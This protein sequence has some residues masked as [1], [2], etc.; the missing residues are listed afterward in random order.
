MS[1]YP[2]PERAFARRLKSLHRLGGWPARLSLLLP[3]AGGALLVLQTSTLAQ[4]LHRAVV[5]QEAIAGLVGPLAVVLALVVAR[6]GIGMLGEMLAVLASEAIKLT[7]RRRF[8]G[9]M[10]DRLPIWTAGQSSGALSTLIIEQIESLDG[11]FT[12]Y[13]PAMVQAAVLPIAFAV[14]VFPVDWTVGLIFLVTA[15][16]IPIFM[17]LA[18]WG[19]EA[20]SRQQARAL[21]RLTG[22]FADRLRGMVTL[23]LFGREEAETGAIF[24]SSEE[25]RRRSMKVMRIAFLSSAVLEFFSALGVAGVALYCGL[26]LLGLI[27]LRSTPMELEAALFCLLMAPEVYQPLRLLAASY[28]DRA[29]ARAALQEIEAGLAPTLQNPPTARTAALPR[30]PGGLHIALRGLGVATPGG[31]SVLDDV[32]LQSRPGSHIAILGPSGIGKSTLLEALARLRPISG[33][34]R[35]DGVALSDIAED[36]L[37]E[38]V[39]FI[40]QRPRLFAG[41]IAENI[42]LARPTACDTAVEAAAS[43]AM[44]S[45]F[46]CKLPLG[47]E[48]QVGESGYGVSGGEAQRVALARL[49]LRDPRLILLD[50]PTAHLDAATETEVLTNLLRFAE[51]RT[52]IVATHAEAVAAKMDR[53]YRIAGGRLLPALLPHRPRARSLRGAA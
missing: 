18:G 3:L 48:T 26:T 28:H 7:L 13:L 9:E 52:L 31:E 15:P 45:A 44:V 22:R 24:A 12:R 51:G 49:Y 10:M 1:Q 11:F 21:S 36:H 47:L 43:R 41:T 40:G 50:E 19:A 14:V 23:K 6:A 25:L 33:E 30:R 16:L 27:H 5:E 2:T 8:F 20:A 29:A 53:A 17:M 38:Q 32:N 4:V 42:R 34:I 35:L 46:A 39:A 37:R